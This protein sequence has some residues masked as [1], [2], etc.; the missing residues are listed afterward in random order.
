MV[1]NNARKTMLELRN[2]TF[3]F[4][5]LVVNWN[6]FFLYFITKNTANSLFGMTHIKKFLTHFP[7]GLQLLIIK[8]T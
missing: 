7:R 3:Q 8:N 6:S 2:N 1:T 5:Y 4:V